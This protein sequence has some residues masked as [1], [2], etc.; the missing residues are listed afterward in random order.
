MIEQIPSVCLFCGS[1]NGSKP[2]FRN[3]AMRFGS[4]VAAEDWRLVYGAGDV[5]L[6]GAAAQAA[7]SAGGTVYGVMPRHLFE[8][9]VARNDLDTLI[10][11][12]TMHERKMNMFEN[13]DAIVALPG[14]LG[15]LDEFFEVLTW[16]QLGLHSKPLLLLNI[17]HYWDGLFRLMND[18]IESGFA[19]E[20]I[21]EVY[22]VVTSPEAVIR[23]LRNLLS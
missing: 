9:E 23:E 3:A 10:I 15:T 14:G 20:D 5:G 4:L 19:D 7:I 13:S 1:R 6:M 2:E 21:R 17:D 22:R 16:R 8:M 12:D 18:I 11:T